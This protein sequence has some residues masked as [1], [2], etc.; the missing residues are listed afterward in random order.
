M[1]SGGTGSYQSLAANDQVL[2][3]DEAGLDLNY[4]GAQ[5]GFSSLPIASQPVPRPRAE[6]NSINFSQSLT[7]IL[8]SLGHNLNANPKEGF[9][10]VSGCTDTWKETMMSRHNNQEER[11]LSLEHNLFIMTNT[12]QVS[13]NSCMGLQAKFRRMHEM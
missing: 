10:I 5:G 8:S 7:Q 6:S 13:K 1:V 3:T 2:N 9:A 12:I 4:K 11:I